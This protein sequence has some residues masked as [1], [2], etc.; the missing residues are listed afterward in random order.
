M[1]NGSLP[2]VDERALSNDLLNVQGCFVTLN[3]NKSLRGCIG[4]IL[5]QESLYKCI[6]DNA[7]SAA[8]HDR[9]FSPVTYDELKDIEIE[10]SILSVPIELKHESW[11]DLLDK[12]R[13]HVDCVVLT[14]GGHRSTYLPQVWEQI[15]Q[16]RE[17]LDESVQK[18][19]DE[20]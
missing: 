17:I 1:S 16:K 5:P 6:M 3:K 20:L 10:I 2:D 9:R 15:P 13:P 11:E 12:L 14:Q 4:H 8:L 19:R 7:I 18:R